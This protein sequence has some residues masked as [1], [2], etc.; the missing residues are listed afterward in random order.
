MTLTPLDQR[1]PRLRQV[2]AKVTKVQLRDRQ[3]QLEI[4]AL[5]DFVHGVINKD[6]PGMKRDRGKPTTVGLAGCQVGIMKQIMIVDLSVGRQGYSDVHVLIN[7]AVAWRSKALISK[8]EGCVNFPEVWGLTHRVRSVKV[9]ALDRSGNEI[10]LKLIGWPA[11]LIQHEIDHL[12]GRLFIDRLENPSNAHHVTP[13]NYAQYRR[14]RPENWSKF[15]DMS[16]EAVP[17]PDL[18][19]PG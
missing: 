2:C 11:V 6:Q 14:V 3:Q 15:I 1:D 9:C 17:L 10:E 18:Y 7:P 13:E 4:D 8:P 5:L 19:L 12:N 16:K